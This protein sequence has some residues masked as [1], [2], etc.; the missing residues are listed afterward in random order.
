MSTTQVDK[1]KT[2]L[3]NGYSVSQAETLSSFSLVD[4]RAF[5]SEVVPV[6]GADRVW[7]TMD[8][9]AQKEPKAGLRLFFF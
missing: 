2:A 3:A 8:G 5:M 6:G 9:R 7:V 1:F 4:F